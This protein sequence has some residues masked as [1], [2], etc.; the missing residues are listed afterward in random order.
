MGPASGLSEMTRV[1]EWI[2]TVPEALSYREVVRHGEPG[3]LRGS[4]I[5]RRIVGLENETRTPE[6][7]IVGPKRRYG[8]SFPW[9]ERSGV[10][11]GSSEP[12]PLVI[13]H[14]VRL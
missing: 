4:Q 13:S 11:G 1:E 7:C 3:Q 9:L 2:R 6:A 14:L 8:H 5:T 10:G 12:S